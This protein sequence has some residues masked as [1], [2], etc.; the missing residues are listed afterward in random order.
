MDAQYRELS[1][2]GGHDATLM[3]A[4]SPKLWWDWLKEML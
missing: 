4:R 2:A 3:P 1:G